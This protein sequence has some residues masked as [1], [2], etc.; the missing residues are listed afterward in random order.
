M[1]IATSPVHSTPATT[2]CSKRG[3]SAVK[4]LTAAAVYSL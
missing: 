4:L 3:N 1:E 2:A